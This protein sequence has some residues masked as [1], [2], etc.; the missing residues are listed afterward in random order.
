M[1]LKDRYWHLFEYSP[2]SFWEEDFSEV[3]I[4]IEHLR[5]QGI[6]DFRI[7]FN[8]HPEIVVHCASLVK[9]LDVNR[10]TLLLF[11]AESKDA[12]LKGLNNVFSEAS[13]DV[14]R[15]ELIAIA[16]GKTLFEGE[17][18]VNTLDGNEIRTALRWSVLPEHELTYSWVLVSVVDITEQTILKKS[19]HKSLTAAQQL[20]DERTAALAEKCLNLE[21]EIEEH[22]QVSEAL[23][24][25]EERYR[26]VVENVQIGIA[27]I[28][29]GME[30]MSLN[31]QMR[32]WFPDIN[33]TERPICYQAFNDPPRE[34]VCSYCPTFQTLQ[35]GTVHEAVTHTSQKERIVNYRIVASPV[36]DSEG[37]VVAAIEMVEDVTAKLQAQV[38]LE[39]S[40]N[41]Y[42]AIFENTGTAI[43]IINDDTTIFMVNA[44]FA[45]QSG[46]SKEELVGKSEW[47]E[48]ISKNDIGKMMEYH[49]LR[50]IDPNAAPSHYEFQFIDRAGQ[51]KDIF[52]TIAMI[53]GTKR[54]VA[55]FLDITEKNRTEE[56]LRNRE[57][58]L[59]TKS[60]NLEEVNA[61]LRV[62]LRQR[63]E[64]KKEL[65]EKLL[66][67]VK[68]LVM[69][70]VE[71]LKN[72]SHTPNQL[73]CLSIL[74]TNLSE[75]I[76]P[77][78]KN[79]TMKH[80]D[81]T[82]RE[83]QIVNLVKN[84]KTTKEIAE[85]FNVSTSAIDFHRDNIRI[86]L[87]LKNKKTNLRS[88]LLTHH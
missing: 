85:L 63:D 67:N 32:C 56:K 46:F 25:S 41:L 66:A 39:A 20:V 70:Y 73:A 18:I 12:L 23:R 64:D 50:R 14:F 42:R 48:L 22:K 28:S 43:A 58:E 54:S 9:V 75:I 52:A 51:R 49:L 33:V 72:I 27:L 61:A 87:K 21:K 62:L 10:A 81:L 16:E 19:L 6:Q 79:I 84:G 24:Q 45:K 34:E 53:P 29:P 40:E 8:S 31:K 30:V 76:S 83:I 74:E 80:I 15:Y 17:G 86:K 26:G 68:E 5:S 3:K 69:P 7:Y 38:R 47:I 65:E 13:Y 4:F 78:L 1:E 88:Y 71:K 2:I 44:E 55:S 77:F 59:S 11:K 35:D 60:M 37:K 57:Q 82:P 36:K